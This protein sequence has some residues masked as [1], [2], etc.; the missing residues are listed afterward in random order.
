[1]SVVPTKICFGSTG[2]PMHVVAKDQFSKDAARADGLSPYC[3][4]CAAARQRAWK[5]ANPEKVK[6]AKRN[7]R[8]SQ[9]HTDAH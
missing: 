6:A 1:M 5:H 9:L 2:Q 4:S 3:K 8:K 7:Y